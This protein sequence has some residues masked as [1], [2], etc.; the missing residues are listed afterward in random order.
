MIKMSWKDIVK[1][2]DWEDDLADEV[3]EVLNSNI[4]GYPSPK[5]LANPKPYTKENVKSLIAE[6]KKLL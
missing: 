6:L 3:M 1:E 5:R 2:E 4:L